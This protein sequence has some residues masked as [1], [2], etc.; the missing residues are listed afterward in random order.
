MERLP[1]LVGAKPLNGLKG[2]LVF[3]R[4]GDWEFD[5][6]KVKDSIL[7]FNGGQTPNPLKGPIKVRI[8]V[9]NAGTESFISVYAKRIGD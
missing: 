2:P 7:T 5:T 3:L 4:E 6:S 8:E 9:A 1:L